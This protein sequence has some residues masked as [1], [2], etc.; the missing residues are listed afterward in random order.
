[1]NKNS[2]IPRYNWDYN[3]SDLGKAYRAILS[4]RSDE[5]VAHAAFQKIFGQKPVFTSSGRASLYAILKSLKIPP[6][7]SVGVPLFCCDIVSF[8]VRQAGFI[9]RFIDVDPHDYNMSSSDLRKKASELSALV[10]AHMF[11]HPADMDE[12]LECAGAIPVIEDCAHSFLSQYKGRYAGFLSDASFFSFRSGKYLSAGEGSAVFTQ[13]PQLSR[14]IEKLTATF[15]PYQFL[16]EW[17]HCTTTYMKSTLYHRPWYGM[18]GY[19]VG[20]RLDQKLNL[21]AKTGLKL[22]KISRADLRIVA[23]RAEQFYLKI[24]RQRH[25]SLFLLENIKMRDIHLPME[26]DGCF[27]NFYQ[28]PIRFNDSGRRDF[29]ADYLFRHGIDTAKYLDD[30]VEITKRSYG[31]NGDCP[32]AECC[33]KTTL[34]IPNHY[35]LLPEDMNHIVEVLNDSDKHFYNHTQ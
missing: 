11:G 14:S 2:L 25:N 9:P 19:P 3:F 31:Y 16:E 22:K 21:S 33:S 4:D 20:R 32:N 8:T 24:E 29:V 26:A 17:M 6:G 27:S 28:F 23:G 34:V 12:I 18:V 35:N 13:D 1:M 15:M 30:I 5:T 7:S 10:V